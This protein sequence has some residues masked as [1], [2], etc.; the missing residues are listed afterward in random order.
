M[1]PWTPHA[2]VCFL[3]IQQPSLVSLG[4]CFTTGRIPREDHVEAKLESQSYA[5]PE[6]EPANS[7]H[8]G[9]LR[10]RQPANR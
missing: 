3:K 5:V 9:L 4:Q 6:R 10:R 1:T 2:L 7:P 8:K